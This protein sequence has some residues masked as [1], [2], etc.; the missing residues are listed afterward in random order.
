MMAV[1]VILLNIHYCNFMEVLYIFHL[2]KTQRNAQCTSLLVHL[3]ATK[4]PSS[5]CI[6]NPK[7]WT[8][9]GN[10][11]W[12]EDTRSILFSKKTSVPK[13]TEKNAMV[14]DVSGD[15]SLRLFDLSLRLESDTECT[16]GTGRCVLCSHFERTS[17]DFLHRAGIPALVFFYNVR[18]KFIFINKYSPR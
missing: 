5:C 15:R 13:R 7:S 16:A 11:P 6:L 14:V 17:A 3:H 8:L 12:W 4:A 9:A 2:K 18:L 1:K 10:P